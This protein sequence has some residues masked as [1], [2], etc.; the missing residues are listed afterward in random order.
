VQQPLIDLAKTLDIAVTGYSS[1]GPQ[2]FY[3]LSMGRSAESLLEHSAVVP[4]ASSHNKTPAQVVL[5]WATQRGVA[6][7]PKSN[8]VERLAQNL[9]STDFDLS[10]EQLK[11]ISALDAGIRFNNPVEIDPRMGI[12]C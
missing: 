11:Q 5:R 7:V 8:N 1:F 12:F 3:E 2:G 6:V 10:D 9:N 4:I